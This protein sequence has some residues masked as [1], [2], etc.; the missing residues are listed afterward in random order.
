MLSSLEIETKVRDAPVCSFFS[1]RFRSQSLR[2]AAPQSNWA[3]E[4]VATRARGARKLTRRSSLVK[5]SRPSKEISQT[6]HRLR[7]AIEDGV[8]GL[9]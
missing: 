9:P 4:S 3:V 7:W 8:E 5:H 1:A 2:L 6:A